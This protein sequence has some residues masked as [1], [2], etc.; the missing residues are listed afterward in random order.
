MQRNRGGV[1]LEL[2][3]ENAFV[4]R[5]KRRMLICLVSGLPIFGR[6][7]RRAGYAAL[8]AHGNRSRLLTLFL[9]R[10]VA[11]RLLPRRDIN[12]RFSKLVEVPWAFEVMCRAPP[13]LWLPW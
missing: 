9:W 7:P 5:V 10:G 13:G 11:V 12:D 8:L 4:K 2:F 3:F 1:V 6:H